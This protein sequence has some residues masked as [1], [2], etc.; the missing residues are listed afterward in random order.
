MKHYLFAL[1][2]ITIT[3]SCVHK[4]NKASTSNLNYE[5][6]NSLI[7]YEKQLTSKREIFNGSPDTIRYNHPILLDKTTEV[8]RYNN[9]KFGINRARPS[10]TD[11]KNFFEIKDSSYVIAQFQ[12]DP[13]IGLDTSLIKFIS[14]YNTS[15][16]QIDYNLKKQIIKSSQQDILQ[17][18]PPY[19]DKSN[20]AIIGSIRNCNEYQIEKL[21][22]LV[23]INNKWVIKKEIGVTYKRV[24]RKDNSKAIYLGTIKRA[25]K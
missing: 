14:I 23:K 6:I 1:I 13:K 3:Y 21:F 10:G 17:F 8:L 15:T 18:S 19:F 4:E 12:L 7:E 2:V 16:K 20:N 24:D 11:F 22:H 9:L 25:Y 5:V